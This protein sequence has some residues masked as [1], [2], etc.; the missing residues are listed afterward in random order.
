MPVQLSMQES[1]WKD[2]ATDSNPS[3]LDGMGKELRRDEQKLHVNAW[4]GGQGL[5]GQ[6]TLDAGELATYITGLT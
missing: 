6:E 4:T 2:K 3:T 5:E 1:Y